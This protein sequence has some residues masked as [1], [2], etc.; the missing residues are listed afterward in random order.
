MSLR[1]VV[2]LGIGV[3]TRRYIRAETNQEPKPEMSFEEKQRLVKEWRSQQKDL[4]EC[5]ALSGYW[6]LENCLARQRYFRHQYVDNN[7][8]ENT[9]PE[10]VVC[11][12]SR[13]PHYKERPR[14]KVCMVTRLRGLSEEGLEHMIERSAELK[15]LAQKRGQIHV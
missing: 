11:K 2:G 4:I 6:K 15:R 14:G 10:F 5:P 1:V 13:C 9:V 7:S 8:Q 3:D 12:T